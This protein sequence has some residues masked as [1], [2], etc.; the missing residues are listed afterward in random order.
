MGTA[1]HRNIRL[2]LLELGN[3]TKAE[4][5][6]KLALS[7]PTVSKS[8]D[9]MKLAGEIHSL[10]LDLSSGGRRAERYAYNPEY[11]LGLALL[12]RRNETYYCLINSFGETIAQERTPGIINGGYEEIVPYIAALITG[13][14]DIGSIAVGVPA[15]VSNGGN[16][17]Y[18]T[19]NEPFYEFDLKTYLEAHFSIPVTVENDMNA[20]VLGYQG[21]ESGRREANPS[22]VYL[23]FG[24]LGPGAGVM[25][26]GD[27]V[28]GSTF[29]SGEVSFVP[30]YELRNFGQSLDVDSRTGDR[31]GLSDLGVD[32]VG[33]LVATFVAILNP[34]TI[35]FCED[36]L[37]APVLDR[38]L[39]R[40]ARYVPAKHLPVLTISD[41]KRDYI[42]GLNRLGHRLLIE[43]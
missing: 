17:I 33:R 28:R 30:Q 36:D 18:L 29:F 4:L 8:L 38:I 13:H 11:R 9:S 20:A 25:I 41:W 14:P 24:Q 15:P 16:I 37:T 39:E 6:Q 31:V 5:S 22:L 42:N 34:H 32:A 12:L 3:A 21:E 40:S 23:H 27:V 2:A 10:G 7:F 35:I 43:A 19:G 26:N 1:I